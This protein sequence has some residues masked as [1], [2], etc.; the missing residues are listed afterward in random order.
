[1]IDEIMFRVKLQVVRNLVQT[2][3]TLDVGCG[4]QKYTKFLPNPVGIDA[5]HE[6]D[7]IHAKPDI[8]MNATKLEF[9]DAS[10]DNICYFDVLEH[11]PFDNP[12]KSEPGLQTAVKE[13]HRVLKPN[14]IVAITDP[15]DSMLFWARILTLRFGQAFRG[16]RT[17]K[18]ESED[19]PGHI[20][21]FN[22][23]SL[24]K[25]MSPYFHLEMSISR[26]IFTGY[27][28][29]RSAI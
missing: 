23:D 26:L 5:Y 4:D 10:F 3:K 12:D 9:P 2:G 1:M 13:A 27:R 6:C 22:R 8:W 17:P 29:R 16:R 7:H 15:N 24:I 11:I 25:L 28:F 19:S 18:R 21:Q 20:H 14:G